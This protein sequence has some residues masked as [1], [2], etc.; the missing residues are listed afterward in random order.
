MIQPKRAQRFDHRAEINT[1]GC[2]VDG[3]NTCTPG[4]VVSV[5]LRR[6]EVYGRGLKDLGFTSETKTS[7][8]IKSPITA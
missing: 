1:I 6:K 2:A 4:E 5:G 8:S 7:K 3:R